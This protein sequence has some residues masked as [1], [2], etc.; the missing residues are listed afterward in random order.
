M[1]ETGVTPSVHIDDF[2]FDLGAFEFSIFSSA[3]LGRF[4]L[5]DSTPETFFE[6]AS[7]TGITASIS[8]IFFVD[9]GNQR[10]GILDSTPDFDLDV[11]GTVGIDGALTIGDATGD[12]VTANADSWTFANDTN[13]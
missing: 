5:G 3:S 13:F 12:T 11:A 10:I 6:I 9:A 8:N 1:E 2:R 4:S 7:S